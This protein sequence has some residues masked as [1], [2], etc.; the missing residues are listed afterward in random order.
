GSTLFTDEPVLHI[1][2]QVESNTL[3][4]AT[5]SEMYFLEIQPSTNLADIQEWEIFPASEEG[6][7]QDAAVWGGDIYLV[8]GDQLWKLVDQL[9]SGVGVT[10]SRS[11]EHT[12]ELQSR[13]NLVCR[14]LL[15]KKKK[16]T[17]NT[18]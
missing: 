4:A 12:S 7:I 8:V 15:E 9:L 6:D 10:G 18:T 5:G 1:E 14:L 2:A 16:R 13:E 17:L 11:E 3:F